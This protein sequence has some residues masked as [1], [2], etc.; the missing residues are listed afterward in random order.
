MKELFIVITLSYDLSLI[1]V[2]DFIKP[3]V[4]R[5][6]VSEALNKIIRRQSNALYHKVAHG[7]KYTYTN[8]S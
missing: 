2:C 8:Y 1:S 3:L 5:C 4:D 7:K 6:P